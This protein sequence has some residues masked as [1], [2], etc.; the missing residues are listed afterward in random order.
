LLALD[1][2]RLTVAVT[3]EREKPARSEQGQVGRLV[4]GTG[5]GA[6]ERRDRY[7]DQAGIA[8]G[9]VRELVGLARERGR[10]RGL[11]DHVT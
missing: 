2:E 11:Y 9:D 4:F 3:A 1:G 6:P 5:T 10:R 7:Q 8:L